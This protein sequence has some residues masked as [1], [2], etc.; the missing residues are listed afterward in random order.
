VSFKQWFGLVEVRDV[1][2]SE[3]ESQRIAQGVTAMWTL[4]DRLALDLPIA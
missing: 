4:V 1:C 2:S 3:D